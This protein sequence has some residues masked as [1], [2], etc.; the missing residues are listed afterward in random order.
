LKASLCDSLDVWND[1]TMLGALDHPDNPASGRMEVEIALP[2]DAGQR[3]E[4]G[5]HG[6]AY[7]RLTRLRENA[8]PRWRFHEAREAAA[9]DL[10]MNDVAHAVPRTFSSP[11]RNRWQC[12]FDV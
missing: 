8:L 1:H 9:A 12:D 4:V 7:Q 2:Q 6:E 5:R 3:G 10:T 11:R